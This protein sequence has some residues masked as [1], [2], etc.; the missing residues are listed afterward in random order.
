MLCE[1]IIKKL[2]NLIRNY[3]SRTDLIGFIL[4]FQDIK[5]PKISYLHSNVPR[6]FKV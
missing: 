5:D 1:F 4:T 6:T 2:K 3:S